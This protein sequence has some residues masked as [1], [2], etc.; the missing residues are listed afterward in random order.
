MARKGALTAPVTFYDTAPF[1]SGAPQ[2]SA[3]HA[4]DRGLLEKAGFALEGRL[5]RSA[6]KAGEALDQWLYARCDDD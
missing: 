6:M 5:R 4:N 2:G 1:S 3:A